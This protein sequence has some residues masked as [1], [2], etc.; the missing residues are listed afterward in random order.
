MTVSI[1]FI[2]KGLCQLP[3]RRRAVCGA[4]RVSIRFIAK[5]LCQHVRTEG[6]EYALIALEFLFALSRRVSV[7]FPSGWNLLG[8]TPSF[9]SLYRE[10]S[11][12]TD[13]APALHI[14][15]GVSIRF[16]A[17]GLCQQASTPAR[18]HWTCSGVSIRF[19]AKGLCQRKK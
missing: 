11:L 5:G 7:N 16:I 17:K 8:A 13:S 2:A 10:G 12:S 19:I 14:G 1:R 3:N 4:G 9:Y 15:R 6:L 18:C